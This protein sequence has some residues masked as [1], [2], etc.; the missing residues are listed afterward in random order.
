V[1]LAGACGTTTPAPHE[2]VVLQTSGSG[3]QT[4]KE[5]T[6]TGP[7]SIAWSFDCGAD[8][9]GS[10]FLDVFNASD[11]TPDFKNRGVDVEGEKHDSA[12]SRFANPGTFYLEIT[13]T[14]SWSI[15]VFD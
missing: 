3:T 13:S 6:V 11:H 7:W 2:S 14:C 8:S 4:T 1:V 5:F 10:F 9:G 12:T 15:R